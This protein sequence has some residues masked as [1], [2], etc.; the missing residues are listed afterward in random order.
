[1]AFRQWFR[2]PRH[3]LTIFL[4][5]AVVSAGAL[6]WLAWLLVEQDRALEVQRRQERLEQAAD[7]ATAVMQGALADLEL[8]LNS[9]STRTPESP[10][11]VVIVMAGPPGIVVRPDGG[12]LYYPEPGQ[13]SESPPAPFVEAEHAEFARRDLVVAGSLYAALA[14]GA[15]TSVR[16]R[17]L[18]GLARVCRKGQRPDAALAAYD[19]LAEISGVRVAGLPPGLIA[20][21]GRARVFEETGRTSELRDE[22]A[23]LDQALRRGRWRLTKSQYQF[24][25]AEALRWL[26]Q[27]ESEMDT[28]DPE[29]VALADAVQWLW[30]SCNQISWRGCRTSFEARCQRCVRLRKCWSPIALCL[31]TSGD[32]PTVCLLVRPTACAGW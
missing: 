32:N 27:P 28:A 5:V 22:A 21:T 30:S 29:A 25:S 13:A 1:M 6:G 24:Y 3:V 31:K 8:Q 9:N 2:P 12:L 23:Q 18:A 4:S 14:S 7:R 15:D 17:A 20:R 10:P 26:G 19:E 16:A 11:G